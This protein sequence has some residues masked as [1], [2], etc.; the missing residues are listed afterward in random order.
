[1]C[2]FWGGNGKGEGEEDDTQRMNNDCFVIHD[3]VLIMLVEERKSS[4]VERV[5]EDLNV[6]GYI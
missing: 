1:M 5:V 3:R 4:K 6:G 2:D